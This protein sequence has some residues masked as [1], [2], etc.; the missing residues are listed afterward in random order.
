MEQDATRDAL[1]S[2]AQVAALV[3]VQPATVRR[4]CRE[5]SL[6]AVRLGGGSA[7]NNPLRIRVSDLTRQL[8]L[9][10]P[11]EKPDD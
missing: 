7:R 8:T 5:G 10:G 1:L 4:W 9:A 11:R 3:G 2:P 6:P